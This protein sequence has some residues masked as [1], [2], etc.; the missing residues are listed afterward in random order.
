L[1]D[2]KLSVRKFI[3]DDTF[4]NTFDILVNWLAS[5]CVSDGFAGY[6]LALS[7]LERTTDPVIIYF[8]NGEVFEKHVSDKIMPL[9]T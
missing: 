9:Q 8:E 7:N 6:Y 3:D 5:V 4:N 1:S 2:R